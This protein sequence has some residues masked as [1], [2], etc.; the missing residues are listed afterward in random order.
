MA[1]DTES[2]PHPPFDKYTAVVN[3]V[4]LESYTIRFVFSR[5]SPYIILFEHRSHHVWPNLVLQ[6]VVDVLLCG[7]LRIERHSF[8]VS[9][10]AAGRAQVA[11]LPFNQNR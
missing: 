1:F 11:S 3:I 2:C 4:Q 5:Y 7:P 9:V 10:A 6:F 8:V